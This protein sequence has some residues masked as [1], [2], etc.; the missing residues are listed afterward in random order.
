MRGQDF[1][2]DP[3]DGQDVAAAWRPR[4]ANRNTRALNTLRNFIVEVRSPEVV[5][6][7][8]G[9]QADGLGATL[10]DLTSHFAAHRRDLAF[11]RTYARLTRVPTY[12]A[13][14]RI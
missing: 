4:Q 12:H 9:R 7:S 5:V 3:A 6:H 13:A 10:R 1:F 11:Q 2:L 8:A 14:N